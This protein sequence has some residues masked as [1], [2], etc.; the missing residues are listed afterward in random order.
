MRIESTTD[1]AEFRERAGA[2]LA[3][4]PLRHTVIT[5][6][7]DNC[8]ADRLAPA[9]LF[10]SVH[11]GDAVVGAAM[12]T[13]GYRVYLGE[14]PEAAPAEL[15][16]VFYR[17]DP[18]SPGVDAD[19]RSGRAFAEQWRTLSGKNFRETDATRLYR[20]GELRSP[21]VPGGVRCATEGDLALCVE[22]VERMRRDSGIGPDPATVPARL[23]KGHLWLWEDAGRVVAFVGH[24]IRSFGW[25][26]LAPVYT[27]PEFRC[28]GYG[29][30]VTA[31][32][33][34]VLRD[35]GSE[36]CL[37]AQIANPTSNKIYQDIGYEP[38]ADFPQYTFGP[39]A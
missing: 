2:F 35:S 10:V 27:P 6:M 37:F 39:A 19:A 16:A 29:S 32:V 21:A 22:W 15:A 11:S 36:V 14:V 17:H 33:S 25:T 9:P 23:A 7:V 18:E 24:Q 12:K 5:T 38:V 4:D 3:R 13:P 28:R 30:A 8:A 20:L 26:R 31:A 1:A 34:K